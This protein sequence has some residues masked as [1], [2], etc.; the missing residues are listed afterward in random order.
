LLPIVFAPLKALKAFV[1]LSAFGRSREDI[2]R[3]SPS[4]RVALDP[5]AS[6]HLSREEQMVVT[7]HV[8][9]IRVAA[10]GVFL[11]LTGLPLGLAAWHLIS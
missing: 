8:T 4:I 6:S 11:L 10:L 2:E 1:R 3:L 7:A 9:V 5:N